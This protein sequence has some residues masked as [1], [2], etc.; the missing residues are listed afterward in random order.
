MPNAPSFTYT[1]IILTGLGLAVFGAIMAVLGLGG[2]TAFDGSL[3]DTRISTSNVGLAILVVGSLLAGV[4]AL[5]LP[6][7]V[8]VFGDIESTFGERLADR[9]AMPS[10]ITA[11][12]GAIS[13]LVIFFIERP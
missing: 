12:L 4:V 2:A 7:N 5:K 8:R 10:L 3:G 13:L 6:K 11:I 1:A 9:V